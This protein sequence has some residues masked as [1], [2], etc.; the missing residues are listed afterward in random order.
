M[1]R[2]NKR[3]DT[4]DLNVGAELKQSNNRLLRD[5]KRL[6]RKLD[7][8]T[9]R[10]LAVSVT[11]AHQEEQIN[12]LKEKGVDDKNTVLSLRKMRW[13]RELGALALTIFG[14][15]SPLFFLTEWS[16]WLFYCLIFCTAIFI[17]CTMYYSSRA[18]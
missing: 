8:V 4:D 2:K 14:A 5:N 7:D 17:I 18:D 12:H 3:T 6:Q 16:I 9:D 10:V 13:H 11:N 15:S 1:P